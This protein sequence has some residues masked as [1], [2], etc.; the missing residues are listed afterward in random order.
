MIQIKAIDKEPWVELPKGSTFEN[1]SKDDLIKYNQQNRQAS[2]YYFFK[3]AFD[4]LYCNEIKGDYY[5][6]GCHTARTFRMALTEAKRQQMDD[7]YFYAFDSFE[8]LPCCDKEDTNISGWTK[9]ALTTTEDDFIKIIH[10]HG[11]YTNRVNTV[12]G[13]YNESL[14]KDLQNKLLKDG[15][16]ASLVCVDCDLYMS[17]KD[18]FN[19]LEPFL[20]EGTLVYIDDMFAGHKGSPYKGV[21]KALV[22]FEKQT[23]FV[24]EPHMQVGWHGRSFVTCILTSTLIR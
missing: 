6:F 21:Y 11:I 7:I 1:W 8:G 22:E 23:D 18:V 2:K 3:A 10:E 24:F 17:A 9:G 13:F 12:K 14:N 15:S 16:K 4:F 19:F 20:Q 5:E